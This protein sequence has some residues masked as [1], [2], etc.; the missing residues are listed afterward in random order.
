VALRAAG[1][2][3]GPGLPRPASLSCHYVGVADYDEV[4][5]DVATLRATRRAASVRVSLSQGGQPV[6]EA[7]V[8]AVAAG[9]D[10]L[11][12][13]VTPAPAVPPPDGLASLDDLRPADGPHF[14][15]WENIDARPVNWGGDMRERPAGEPEWLGWLRFRPQPAF[16]DPWVDAGRLAVAVDTLMWPAA[17]MGYAYDDVRFIAPSLDLACRFHRPSSNQEWLL[18]RACSPLAT[19]GLVAGTAF[20]W[21]RDGRLVASGGQQMLCRPASSPTG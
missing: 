11:S 3:V 4:E 13:D 9:L 7:L 17:V 15:F 19:G 10:G 1:A 14:P 5:I 21:G 8:W 18:L 12:H 16:D 2:H 6:L 20:L